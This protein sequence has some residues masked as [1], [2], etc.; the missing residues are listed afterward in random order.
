MSGLSD[1]EIF[2][3]LKKH[4]ARIVC[5]KFPENNPDIRTWKGG[6]IS[7]LQHDLMDQAHG[8]I[9]E[10]WFYTHLKK[11]GNPLPRVD[12]LDLLS[13][14]CGYDNWNSYKRSFIKQKSK[15]KVS[16]KRL[17]GILV[18]ILI[19]SSAF[20]FSKVQYHLKVLDA[21]S[22]KSIHSKNLQVLLINDNDT[23]TVIPQDDKNSF[24]IPASLGRVTIV[25]Q[26]PYY[27]NDTISRYI[28][29]YSYSEHIILYP[30]DYAMMLR[31][32]SNSNVKDW[33]IRRAQLN[34]IFHD[35]A[36]IFQVNKEGELM[37]VFNKKE[38]IDKLS[39]PIA[40]LKQ[41]EIKETRFQKGKIK[42]LRFTS[43]ANTSK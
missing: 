21:Y 28:G 23:Y 8:R 10:K 31:Y 17:I 32:F 6:E 39:L 29:W 40:Q 26:H 13:K 11:E 3:Q 16:A 1:Q 2:T 12:M 4:V 24:H 19:V 14:Y 27:H 41:I 7:N 22:L 43:Y 34:R 20:Y 5:D 42:Y 9:S 33:E 15:P 37:A 35:D 38:F 30:D 25:I 18:L 36:F